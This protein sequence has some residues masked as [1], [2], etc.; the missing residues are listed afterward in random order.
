M[1]INWEKYTHELTDKEKK[2]VPRVI[3][4][5]VKRVSKRMIITNAQ[6]CEQLT[7]E[8]HKISGPRLRK[9]LNFIRSESIIRNIVASS[10]GYYIA[11]TQKD[12]DDYRESINA[13][14]NAI[15]RN[16][17]GIDKTLGG[18]TS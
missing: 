11:T 10:D 18:E 1:I 15:L 4:G 8:G 16:L 3:Q 12:L 17:N 9:I 7:K 6:M 5:I 2:I 14:A 13:R